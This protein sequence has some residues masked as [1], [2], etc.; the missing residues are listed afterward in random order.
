MFE[1][2]SKM[3]AEHTQAFNEL[4]NS[5][6]RRPSPKLSN[7]ARMWKPP[8]GSDPLARLREQS[9][10]SSGTT[11]QDAQD[12]VNSENAWAEVAQSRNVEIESLDDDS[13]GPPDDDVQDGEEP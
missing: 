3:T 7:T 13:D 8:S 4:V 10:A 6:K 9:H 2:F 1:A 11:V 12:I 5:S